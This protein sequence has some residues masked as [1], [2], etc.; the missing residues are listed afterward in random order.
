MNLK[1]FFIR[2]SFTVLNLFANWFL[3]RYKILKIYAYMYIIYIDF[4]LHLYL[5]I[6]I[7]NIFN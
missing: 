7:A 1:N 3:V 5:L 4:C 2:V 6:L